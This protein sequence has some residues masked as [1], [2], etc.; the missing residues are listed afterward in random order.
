MKEITQ[1]PYKVMKNLT[2]NDLTRHQIRYI[3][4]RLHIAE[5][6][7]QK[8]RPNKEGPISLL[9]EIK[10]HMES[11]EDFGGWNKFAKTWDVDEKS[12]L[13]V[14]KRSSSIQSDWNK[15]LKKEAKDLPEIPQKTRI[16][17]APTYKTKTSIQRDSSGK[18]VSTKNNSN[19][20]TPSTKTKK[21]FWDS[22][23]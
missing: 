5:S 13:V 23:K 8:A 19:I 21:S 18:F 2:I 20:N 17:E 1:T 3:C 22:L 16:I 10:D 12:P 9:Y 4:A 11:Q 6:R 7:G 15:A 14:V